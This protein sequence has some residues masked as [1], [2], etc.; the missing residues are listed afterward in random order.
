VPTFWDEPW[1]QDRRVEQDRERRRGRELGSVD[2]SGSEQPSAAAR[3]VISERWLS[4]SIVERL[5]LIFVVGVILVVVDLV[6][7]ILSR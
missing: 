7:V 3:A 4:R 2:Q 5:W 6:V 1:E